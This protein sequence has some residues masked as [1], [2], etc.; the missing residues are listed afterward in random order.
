[1]SPK[2]KAGP[3][4]QQLD[5]ASPEAPPPAPDVGMWAPL[6][7]PADP[8][9]VLRFV[10]RALVFPSGINPRQ[11]INAETLEELTRSVQADGIRDPLL[12]R[13]HPERDGAFQIADGHRRFAAAA[14]ARVEVLPVR[15]VAMDDV[16]FRRRVALANLDRENLTPLEEAAAFADLVGE[17]GDGGLLT[18]AQLAEQTGRSD[19]HI[20]QR[21]KLRA[22]RE[23]VRVLLADGTLPLGHALVVARVPPERQRAAVLA[24][25]DVVACRAL[26][27]VAAWLVTAAPTEAA[28]RKEAIARLKEL[29]AAAAMASAPAKQRPKKGKPKKK[30][31]R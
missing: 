6:P 10:E 1:M 31:G 20:Y 7:S 16:E 28:L 15:V 27:A 2:T 9:G 23:D 21:L 30:G 11:Q 4:V 24:G 18:V 19:T 17:H 22:L 13:P 12:V 14:R 25:V 3:F 29:A 8:L 5:D 26:L